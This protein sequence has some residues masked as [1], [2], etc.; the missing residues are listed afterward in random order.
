MNYIYVVDKKGKPLMPTTRYGHIRRLIKNGK[1]VVI[2]NK[3]FTVRLKYETT[4]IIQGMPANIDT[5]RENIGLAATTETSCVFRANF[6]THNKSVTKNMKERKEYRVSRRRHKRIKKQRKAVH[7]NNQF[8]SGN[9]DVLRSKKECL[10]KNISYPGMQEHITHK[11]CKGKEAKFNNRKREE[12]W[13]TP[14]ARH[15]VQM[16]VD[17]VKRMSKF[18]PITSINIERVSFDFQKLANEDINVWEYSKGPLYGFKDYKDY[19]FHQQEGKCLLCECNKIEFYHHIIPRSKGG[20]DKVSNIAGL[21]DKCH[22][23][24]HTDD[25]YTDKLSELKEKSYKQSISLLNSCMDVIINELSKLYPV[26]VT[27]GYETF[28]KRE[29]LGLSK[30]HCND[31][32]CIG[33]KEENLD[34]FDLDLPEIFTL[35]RFKKKSNNIINTLGSRQYF[36]NNKLVAI[37]RHKG[38]EQKCDSLEEYMSSYFKNHTKLECDKHFHKLKIIPAKKIYTF[39]KENVVHKF[40]NGDKFKYEKKNKIKGNIKT[41]IFICESLKIEENK[42][43]HNKTK[44]KDIKYCK[45]L[46]HDS[47]QFI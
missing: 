19:T 8:K 44:N 7:S 29:K 36:Y 1:A 11:V 10:S 24:V 45:L 26:N 18:L 32:I 15:L 12:G 39:H 6:E 40:K 23:L 31:A 5:G 21:C 37:N 35:K 3:P 20:T 17:A 41:G 42:L 25:V 46:N 43:R 2:N 9:K 30:D 16:H 13:L 33:L 34:K 14:S 22:K 28:C 4:N 47:L 38:F 27:T